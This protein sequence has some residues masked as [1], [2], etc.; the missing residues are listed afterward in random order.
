M[1]KTFHIAKVKSSKE[2]VINGGHL[3]GIQEGQRFLVYSLD[4][5]EIFDPIT[6]K[7]LGK[8]EIVKGTGIATFV[9]GKMCTI[10]SDMY[11]KKMQ[12]EKMSNIKLFETDESDRVHQP[13]D[14]PQIGDFVKKISF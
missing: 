8:L 1:S 13:F 12:I 6:N 9:H 4:G 2:I 10:T 5:E 7:S 11:R 14:N 3:H